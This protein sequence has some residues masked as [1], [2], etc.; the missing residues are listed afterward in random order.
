MRGRPEVHEREKIVNY[1]EY[2]A[3]K[4][5]K[6]GM[7][8]LARRTQRFDRSGRPDVHYYFRLFLKDGL[9]KYNIEYF[10][11]KD[12]EEIARLEAD[13]NEKQAQVHERD[14]MNRKLADAAFRRIISDQMSQNVRM[15]GNYRE[16][17]ACDIAKRYQLPGLEMLELCD[18]IYMEFAEHY[19]GDY[20]HI[21]KIR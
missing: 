21:R 13:I 12:R 20:R 9:E 3:E 15:G 18:S 17:L 5:Y 14:T 6:E 19:K 2:T 7:E 4:K 8:D 1:A 10:I 11:Q 16:Q